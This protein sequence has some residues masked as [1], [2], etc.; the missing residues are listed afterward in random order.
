MLLI[1]SLLFS[2]MAV[3][4]KSPGRYSFRDAGATRVFEVEESRISGVSSS[5]VVL[6]EVDKGRRVGVPRYATRGVYVRLAPGAHMAEVARRAGAAGFRPTDAGPDRWIAEAAS[7]VA[8]LELTERLRQLEGVI[9]AHPLL[10][11]K[12]TPRATPNDP[13]FPHQW[14]L[15][16]TGQSNALPGIDLNITNV[17]DT[18]RGQG[19][20]LA[21]VDDGL[22]VN[23]PDLAANVDTA[24]DWDFNGNDDDPNT[25]GTGEKHGT[26]C[27]GLAAAVGDNG[28]GVI[29]SAPE[30]RLVGLRLTAIE[31]TDEQEA[32]AIAWSNQVIHVKSFSWGPTDDGQT[33]K[34]P[35]PLTEAAMSNACMRG[36]HGRGVLLFW[37]AGNGLEDYDNANADGYAN[38][39]YSITV[40][41]IGPNGK[42]AYYSEPGANVV[43]VA[44]SE[45]DNNHTV[46]VGVATTDLVG[47]SGYNA[48]SDYEMNFGGT[49]ASAPMAAG[50]GALM[51]QANPRLGWRDVQ[52][53]LIRTATQNDPADPDWYVNGAGCYFN[54]RYGAGLINARAAVD[55]ALTWTN[56]GKQRI[57]AMHSNVVVALPDADPIGQSFSFEVTN[58]FRVEHVMV[59]MSVEH[60]FRGDVWVGLTSPSNTHSLMMDT[61]EDANSD[62]EDWPMTSVRNWGEHAAGTWTVQ[63]ADQWE[64]DTGTITQVSLILYGSQDDDTDDDGIDDDW[65]W[66]HFGGL[67]TAG[68]TTDSDGD[69]VLDGHEYL[70]GTQPTNAASYLAVTAVMRGEEE[71]VVEW[72][73]EEGKF[74]SL[75]AT[76]NLAASFAAIATNLAAIPPVMT[77]TNTAPAGRHAWYR[78]ELEP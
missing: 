33:V 26:A 11:R 41:S 3:A 20:Y 48:A 77:I 18:Y 15:D 8:S 30:T 71:A 14:H 39:I 10:A 43:V 56:L 65:E 64:Q 69:H 32:A 1:G 57:V 63:M 28:I 72:P 34:G 38:S 12:Q 59:R 9:E 55:M 24:I 5:R 29:G 44:P 49:S 22:Q 68:E 74:Y 76:T 58:T 17:W 52:E 78:V 45:G 62:Y 67:E 21:I 25:I 19:T 42:Q 40:G 47:S 6:Y 13:L 61:R 2:L 73:A 23:H 7:E 31:A 46:R 36:R 54:H 75:S 4:E 35:G 70:A 16:N 51:L 37:A 27:A 66:E 50:V 60:P 53:I